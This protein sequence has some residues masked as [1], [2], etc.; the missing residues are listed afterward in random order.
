MLT[1]YAEPKS[2]SAIERARTPSDTWPEA[3]RLAGVHMSWVVKD[4]ELT[5]R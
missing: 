2:R 5:W 3:L 1:I 4:A